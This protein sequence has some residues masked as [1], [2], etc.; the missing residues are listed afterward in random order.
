MIGSL[1]QHLC[2]RLVGKEESDKLRQ[3]RSQASAVGLASPTWLQQTSILRPLTDKRLFVMQMRRR[4]LYVVRRQG[5]SGELHG[6]AE[7]L[8]RAANCLH[9]AASYYLPA[10]QR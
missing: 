4:E 6:V 3:S 8:R 7:H 1:L 9:P 5:K 10:M 2:I